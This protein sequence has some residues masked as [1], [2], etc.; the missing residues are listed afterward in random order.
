M[1]EFPGKCQKAGHSACKVHRVTRP[2]RGSVSCGSGWSVACV[3]IQLTLSHSFHFDTRGPP[4]AVCSSLV[5]S[6]A[7]VLSEVEISED[8]GPAHTQLRFAH[9]HTQMKLQSY[10]YRNSYIVGLLGLL[11]R[12]R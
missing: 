1:R 12:Y 9:T 11:H 5:L 10:M 8:T 7:C 2:L 6:R 3:S 4:S